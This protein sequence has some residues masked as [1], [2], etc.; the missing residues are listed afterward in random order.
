MI[1]TPRTNQALKKTQGL[2]RS[3]AATNGFAHF[4]KTLEA[5]NAALKSLLAEQ[6][7]YSGPSYKRVGYTL[8]T[9]ELHAVRDIE[10]RGIPLHKSPEEAVTA[11]LKDELERMNAL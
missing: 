6:C 4:A 10:Q 9:D 7:F 1:P 2:F 11:A 3:A 5:E 8:N